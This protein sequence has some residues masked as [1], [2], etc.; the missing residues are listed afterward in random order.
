MKCRRNVNSTPPT[1]LPHTFSDIVAIFIHNHFESP[2][3]ILLWIG[4]YCQT[5][6]CPAPI[7]LI[8]KNIIFIII[9]VYIH[10]AF[11]VIIII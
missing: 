1:Q 2:K 9:S 10:S 6:S 5:R 3:I 7:C 4:N 11:K 8:A